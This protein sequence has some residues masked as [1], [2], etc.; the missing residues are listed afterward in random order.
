MKIINDT[1]N[2]TSSDT[3]TFG[4]LKV[5]DTFLFRYFDG[6]YDREDVYVRMVDITNDSGVLKNAF[7]L[8]HNCCVIFGKNTPVKKI[9][10]V[11]NVV[12]M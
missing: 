7:R 8:K 1:S 6:T 10:C 9:D 2:D 3:I 4:E 11:V 5:G 12:E